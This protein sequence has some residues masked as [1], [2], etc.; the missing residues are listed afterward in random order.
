MRRRRRIHNS[1]SFK[2]ATAIAIK[3]VKTLAI[4]SKKRERITTWH[5]FVRNQSMGALTLKDPKSQVKIQAR[6]YLSKMHRIKR[7]E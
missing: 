3:A 1:E 7:I 2:R 6:E 5:Q 4:Q